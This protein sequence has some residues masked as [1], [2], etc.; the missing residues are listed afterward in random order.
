MTIRTKITPNGNLLITADNESRRE[1][2]EACA[3]GG[4]LRC[5]DHV[6]EYGLA[7]YMLVPPEA[8]GALTDAP[9]IGEAV[10]N[11]NGDYEVFGGVWWFPAYEAVDPW[12]QLRRK[13]RVVFTLASDILPETQACPVM[14]LDAVAARV[15]AEMAAPRQECRRNV[16]EAVS[17]LIAGITGRSMVAFCR[18]TVVAAAPFTSPNATTGR[19]TR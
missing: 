1:L 6:A 15:V 7:E 13:G 16:R 4:Y 17:A 10:I 18:V 9:I 2:A 5:E 14:P 3:V 8:I 12:E 19:S 11:D